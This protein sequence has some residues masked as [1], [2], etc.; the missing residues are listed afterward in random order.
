MASLVR[1]LQRDI[2]N[3]SKSTTEILRTAKLISAKLNLDD[4]SDFIDAELS[5]YKTEK[6]PVPEYRYTKGGTLHVHN[7]VRGWQMAGNVHESYALAF[8]ISELEILSKDKQC[9]FTPPRHI[10]VQ[11]LDGSDYLVGQFPQRIVIS[12]NQLNR[13]LEAV[14]D[15]ILN[16]TVELE[17]RGIL[18]ENMS[19]DE[20]E[21]SA[22]TSQTFNIQKFTG[23]IGNVSHSNVQLYDYS[24]VH[25]TL[26]E[27]GVPQSERNALENIMD[28]LSKAAPAQKP[29]LIEKAK[30]WVVKNKE[31]LGASAE[32]VRKSLGL[33]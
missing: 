18:G 5:G 7:P 2:L 3:S 9:H 12:S 16:W 20:K 17:K 10:P 4:I 11:G 28:D 24:A 14:K 25:Q 26:K 21:K 6:L 19:F 15:A 29:G 13:I 30:G 27:S 22:A 8:P 33:D 23:I 31:F 32:I 1:D